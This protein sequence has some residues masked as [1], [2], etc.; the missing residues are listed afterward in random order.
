MTNN[1]V[2]QFTVRVYYEDTDAGGVIY[3]SNYV[4]FMERARTEWLRNLGHEQDVLIKQEQLIFAVKKLEIDFIKPARFNDLLTINTSINNL[5]GASIIFSQQ[6][7]KQDTVLCE[8]NVQV[9]S[10]D[11]IT[12]KPKRITLNL[13]ED[14]T[15]VDNR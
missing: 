13:K 15:R 4:N 7:M 3:H 5:S 12:L 11:S 9:V 10:L 2:F 14:L 8:A 6:I 1:N